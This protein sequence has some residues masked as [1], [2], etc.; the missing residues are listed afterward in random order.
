MWEK[1]MAVWRW[2]AYL[3]WLCNVELS[4]V[5][6]M[7]LWLLK[8][9]RDDHQRR[10]AGKHL[11]LLSTWVW[12]FC[13]FYSMRE[14]CLKSYVLAVSQITVTKKKGGIVGSSSR[15]V[16]NLQWMM[17][18]FFFFFCGPFHTRVMCRKLPPPLKHY[19]LISR[20]GACAPVWQANKL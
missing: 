11:A 12:L 2:R 15:I 10:Q 7:S 9:P 8:K 6:L 18:F 4:V 3:P 1:H 16:L 19:S 14:V 20:L 17:I 5:N 13:H